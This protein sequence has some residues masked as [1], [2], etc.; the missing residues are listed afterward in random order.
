[1]VKPTAQTMFTPEETVCYTL[2]FQEEGAGH[3]TRGHT[4]KHQ[5]HQREGERVPKSLYCG[6]CGEEP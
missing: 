3:A 1:M 5:N 4:G 2:R 6:F